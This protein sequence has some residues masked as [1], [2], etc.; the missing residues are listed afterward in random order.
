M[1]WSA[2]TWDALSLRRAHSISLELPRIAL[3]DYHFGSLESAISCLD[4]KSAS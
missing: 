1:T 4:A 2:P 3:I